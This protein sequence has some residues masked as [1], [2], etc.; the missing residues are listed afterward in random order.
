MYAGIERNPI[1]FMMV[2]TQIVDE[3]QLEDLN[4]VLNTADI[5]NLYEVP[6]IEDMNKRSKKDCQEQGLEQTPINLFNC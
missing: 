3:K 1:T 6:D 2:D 5:P 4:N